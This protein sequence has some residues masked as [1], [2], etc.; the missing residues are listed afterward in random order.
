M[1]RGRLG[2]GITHHFAFAVEDDEAQLRWREQLLRAGLSVTPVLDRQYF[3]SIY[4]RDPDGILLE[5]ACWVRPL[6]ERDL[7][8]SVLTRAT[9]ITRPTKVPV[10]V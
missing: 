6:D 9:P 3:K 2:A 1:A 4:F 5:F 10:G 8:D 7:D